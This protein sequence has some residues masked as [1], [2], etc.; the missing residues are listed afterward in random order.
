[1]K[2]VIGYVSMLG[3]AL[4]LLAL[5]LT[6]HAQAA[7]PAAAAHG[8]F[9][10]DWLGVVS[11]AENQVLTLED[12]VPQATFKWRPGTGVR[13]VAEAY[14]HIAFANYGL[15]H[16]ATGKE[17]P[18]DAGFVKDP[19][20]WDTKTTD[21]AEIKKILEKS[22]AFAKEAVGAL[23]DADLD[24]QVKFFGHDM[25]ARAVLIILSAHIDEHLGQSIAYARMNKIVPPWSKGDK[26]MGEK[27]HE[28]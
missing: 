19:A 4:G 24:K 6:N 22:F 21:K 26:T 25:T 20:K 11:Y 7:A 3:L 27:K 5:G 15:I 8:G 12:A 18:A 1:M 16:A 17:P 23:S 9:Q 13:S 2:N 14:M 28:E 10:R